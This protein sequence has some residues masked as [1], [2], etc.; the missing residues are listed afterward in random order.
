MSS[1]KRVVLIEPHAGLHFFSFARIPLLGLP[2]LG[3]LLRRMGLF[4]RIFCEK[5]AP[6]DWHEVSKADLVGISVLT[7][8]AP[9]AY[10]IAAKVKE[11]AQETGKRIWVVMGGPH[12]TFMPGE[13]LKHGADFVVRHE[14][15]TVF[16]LLVEYLREGATGKDLKEIPG[17]SYRDGQRIV[18]NPER[19]LIEDLDKLP[20]PNFSLIEGAERMNVVPLQTSRGCPHDCE[21]CSVVQMF[22]HAV[23]Y[24]SPESVVEELKRIE[25]DFPRR[26]VFFVDDNFSA[27]PP[28]VLSLL[29]AMR[30]ARLRIRWSVQE[31]ISVA[32][33]PEVLRLMRETGCRRLYI[34][35]ESLNPAALAEWKKGQSPEEIAEGVRR[36]H[37]E[38]IAVH[39]MFVL[40][41]DA[42]TPDSII[43]TVRGAIRM[44]LDTAQFFILVPPPGTRLFRKLEGEGR[45]FDRNW[46]HYDG[47]HVVFFPKNMSPWK[48]QTLALWAHE[49]FYSVAR[50]VGW[51]ARL[52]LGNAFF[53]FLGRR[54]LRAWLKENKDY[55]K[56]L[57]ER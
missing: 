18:H 29:E 40:G 52:K 20:P 14:G 16:P 22:G 54:F 4:V 23:R 56:E 48:L 30:R 36:I 31:R 49:K 6:I 13:A 1:L 51:A 2:I 41:A 26:H 32:K 44:G 15:E 11:I 24:R 55:L 42:D 10:R 7:N 46:A 21:F 17:L 33:L 12:V 8:L 35:I 25:K 34:G 37:R 5:L 50:G 39:G 19:P 53:A 9:R 45:I 28:R 3:E 47:H 38:G 57:R 43:N 27:N